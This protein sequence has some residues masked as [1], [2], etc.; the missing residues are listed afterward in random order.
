MFNTEKSDVFT[1]KVCPERP[2]PGT[3]LITAHRGSILI[4]MIVTMVVISVLGAGMLYMTSTS[5]FNEILYGRHNDAYYAAEGGGR[6]AMSVIRDA[7]SSNDLSKLNAINNNQLFILANG[8]KFQITDWVAQS[9]KIN[10][11]SIGEAGSG[12]MLS[13]RQIAYSIQPNIT[14]GSGSN[15]AEGSSIVQNASGSVT[16]TTDPDNSSNPMITLG[17]GTTDTCGVIWLGGS[18][19]LGS[20]CSQNKCNFGSGFRAYFEFRITSTDSSSNSMDRGDGFTF[21]V[22]NGTNNDNTRR[23]GPATGSMGELMCYAGSDQTTNQRGLDFPKFAIEFDTYPNT[24]NLSANGCNSGRDDAGNNNHIALMFWGDRTS[25][26]CSNG[27]LCVSYDDNVHGIPA[28][29]STLSPTNSYSGDGTGGYYERARSTYNW[30]EDNVWHLGRVEVM[31]NSA[32]NTYNIKAWVDCE[33]PSGA[34]ACSATEITNYYKDLTIQYYNSASPRSGSVVPKIDRTVT[35]NSSLP[36]FDTILFGFTEGTGGA[37][38]TIQIRN[39]K[40]YFTSSLVCSN[41]II[42]PD[43]RTVGRAQGSGSVTVSMN[44]I[45]SWSAASSDS[46]LS[47]TSGSSGSGA[48]TINY[49]YERYNGATGTSRTAVIT[50]TGPGSVQTFTLTQTNP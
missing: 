18:A 1:H 49:T 37:T 43:S 21:T 45:C 29:S 3:L 38:Q 42:S 30:L 50:V 28:T 20:I 48:G 22:M 11:T 2:Q 6:Y 17:N 44:G 35:L 26:N 19:D 24:G 47:I 40:M 33:T 7:Y 16:V 36:S 23:G 32:T 46:W 39:F 34:T 15:F 25:G 31:R 41:F 8:S 10:F 13:R 4:V 14:G 27:H 9:G 5:S 12:V